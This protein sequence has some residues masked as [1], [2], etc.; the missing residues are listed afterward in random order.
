MGNTYNEYM[1][2]N[3]PEFLTQHADVDQKYIMDWDDRA[4][5]FNEKSLVTSNDPIQFSLEHDITKRYCNGR[6]RLFDFGCGNGATIRTITT[7]KIK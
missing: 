1:K 4:E 7:S 2:L 6:T 5:R 3:V